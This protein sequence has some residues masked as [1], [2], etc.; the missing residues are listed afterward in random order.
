MGAEGGAEQAG[1]QRSPLC[2][3]GRWPPATALARILGTRITAAMCGIRERPTRKWAS[4]EFDWK[5]THVRYNKLFIQ[6]K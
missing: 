6:I 5:I 1:E 3:A 4:P 2:D